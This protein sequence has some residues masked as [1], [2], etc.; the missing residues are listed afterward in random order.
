[1][2]AI[3]S[4]LNNA[5]LFLGDFIVGGVFIDVMSIIIDV[6]HYCLVVL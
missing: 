3:E 4:I 5:R 1:M 6:K 2:T